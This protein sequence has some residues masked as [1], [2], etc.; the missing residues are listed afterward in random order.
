MIHLID[1]TGENYRRCCALTVSPEQS[2]FV[3]PATTILARA[4]AFREDGA[5]V[6]IICDE[7]AMVGLLLT[8]RWPE[9]NCYIL[10]QFFI[11]RRFQRQ[12]YGRAAAAL[13]LDE[14]RA[15]GLHPT[16]LL[17]CCEGDEAAFRLYQ[18]AGFTPTGE[19]DGD[20][21]VLARPLFRDNL[22]L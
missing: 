22:H 21:I 12:G 7:D 8:R 14:L 13:A 9:D 20:E 6:R 18:Q 11:D 15:E 1:V 2:H 5:R 4:Y 3:A 19:K 17:C 16:V 10:D